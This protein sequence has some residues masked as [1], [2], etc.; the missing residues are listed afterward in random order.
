MLAL[1]L[2]L[3]I[4]PSR[5]SSWL[6]WFGSVTEFILAP[7]QWPLNLVVSALKSGS[8]PIIARDPVIASLEL[9]R[10]KFKD[11]YF[12]TLAELETTRSQVSSMTRG[13]KLNPNPPFKLLPAPVIGSIFDGSSQ[14]LRVRAGA[15]NGITE[16]SVVVVETADLIGR[17]PQNAVSDRIS[18]VLPIID[19][20]S[21]PIT[22]LLFPGEAADS[23]GTV[24]ERPE[25]DWSTAIAA[26]VGPTGAGTLAGQVEA[27]RLRP[28]QPAVRPTVGMIARLR[29]NRWPA[30]AQMLIVGRVSRVD[31]QPNGRD[32]ITVTPRYVL[33]IAE[34]LI[35]VSDDDE[36]SLSGPSSVPSGSAPSSRP[37][38]SDGRAR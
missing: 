5:Y 17:I 16:G 22:V 13:L 30:S 31:T 28:D 10:D 37:G 1:L 18:K 20:A 8:Q 19:R 24:G 11:A 6:N 4:L 29:D 23:L 7:I 14:L 15:R 27:A 35:R 25:S 32:V 2:A 34:V 33:P 36:Q 9:E 21:R 3:A 26:Q 12:R 38:T